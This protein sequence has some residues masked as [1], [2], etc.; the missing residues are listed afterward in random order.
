MQVVGY[1][2]YRLGGWAGA[3]LATTAF[4][5]PSFLLMVVLSIVCEEITAALGSAATPALGGLTAAVVGI[6]AATTYRLAK[7]T[8]TTPMA[9]VVAVAACALGIALR[10]N[11]AWI[12]LAAGM[13]GILMP[14]W[15][16]GKDPSKTDSPDL[17]KA[18]AQR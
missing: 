15:L 3:A 7:P 9:G 5:L 18:G 2:G 10:I 6:L 13:L 14:Q 16:T 17:Q 8:I 1:L 12:V 11:P 4:L